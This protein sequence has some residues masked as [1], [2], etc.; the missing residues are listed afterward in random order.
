MK[1]TSRNSW[2]SRAAAACALAVVLAGAGGCES[3][4]RKFTRKPKTPAKP[5]D[6]II[7][8]EDYTRAMTP[9][10]KYRKHYMMFNYWNSELIS[11]LDSKTPNPKRFRRAS[12]ESLSE[13]ETLR[14]LVTGEPGDRF[15]AMIED[16]RR[17]DQRLQRPGFMPSQ[18]AGITRELER[19]TRGVQR[20]FFWRDIESS[21]Q[22]PPAS[23]APE[24]VSTAGEDAPA[25]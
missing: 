5:L 14:S 23:A 2:G 3:L 7:K 13:L 8:F 6:P 9:L 15:A 19:Q 20:D 1:H 4:Q 10:D 18:A 17:V 12:A 25:P 24:P 22:E 16:R 21:I 11:A